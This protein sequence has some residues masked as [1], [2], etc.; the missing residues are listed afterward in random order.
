MILMPIIMLAPVWAVGLFYFLPLS[1]ALPLYFVILIA[2]AYCNIVMF[3]SMRAKPKT[4]IE[5]MI[6]KETLAIEDIDPEG[7]IDIAGEIWA[8]TAGGKRITAGKPVKILKANGLVLVV[9]A[10]DEYETIPE[11]QQP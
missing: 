2:A 11:T 6:G 7:K 4:G 3:W 10:L 9:E 8:A 5:A 1:T